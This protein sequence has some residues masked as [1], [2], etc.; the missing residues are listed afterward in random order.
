M[1]PFVKFTFFWA[2]FGCS[3]IIAA[4]VFS[5]DPN[6]VNG[7]KALILICLMGAL[8]GYIRCIHSFTVKLDDENNHVQWFLDSMLTP[9]KGA[10]LGMLVTLLL[11]VG[12][13]G[14]SSPN[15]MDHINWIG[16]YGISGVVGL[17]ADEAISKLENVF[18]TLFN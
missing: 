12:V 3:S 15:D 17:F 10:A 4:V 16:L 9:L 11:Q 6:P 1:S 7:T 14:S 13:I 5:W 2:I 18:K 8:G